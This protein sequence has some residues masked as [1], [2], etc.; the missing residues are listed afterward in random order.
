MGW[1]RLKLR[2][3]LLLFAV[4]IAAAPL[5]VAGQS[6]IRVAQDELKSSANEQLAVT[7]RQVSDEFN[8]FF[9]YS[10][11]PA[12]DLIRNAVGGVK[13]GS[14]AKIAL[15]RQGIA[16][17]PDVVS[18]QINVDGAP[19]P[20]LVV[21]EEYLGE[22][23]NKSDNPMAVLRLDR[24]PSPGDE[25][26]LPRASSVVFLPETGDW[27]ATASLPIPD[28]IGGRPANL[29]ARIRLDRLNSYVQD[30]PFAHTGTIQVMDA[31]ENLIFST[32]AGKYDHQVV[33][34]TAL[35][36]L[37]NNNATIAV[38]PF[39]LANGS[40]SLGAIALSRAFPWAILV[41]KDEADAYQTVADM[42]SSLIRWISVGIIAAGIGSLVFALGIS[43]PI[44]RIGQSAI[45]VAKGNLNTRVEGVTSKDE[46]GEL[47]RQF[48]DMIV[49]LN[50][51]FELQKFVSAGTMAAI[52]DSDERTV[53]LGG[54]RRRT[55]MLFA[56][57]R[58]YTAFS[59]NQDPEYVVD[60]LNQYFQRLS[61]VVVAHGGDIDK[62]V[63]D[64]IMAV[65]SGP[66]MEQNA[67]Q[68]AIDIMTAIDDLAQGNK[69]ELRIG[70][71]VDVGEVVVG[72][73]GSD[74]RKDFTVLG[75][76]VNTA[77][78][79]CSAA[80]PDET[81]I[82]E[83]TFDRLEASGQKRFTEQAPLEVKGKA[84]PLRVFS[85]STSET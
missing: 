46:I 2:T 69:A 40:I 55:A 25:A 32:T 29:H 41:E 68:C 57:I 31:E 16:D 13:L 65:F 45:E 21:Q 74:H 36:M 78:R 18:L 47:A 34:T 5:L 70:V 80:R 39:E 28:G 20:V 42:I 75:D 82:T 3:K 11:V 37:A 27:L 58:G 15:L 22:L 83:A 17:L 14:D 85:T 44:L 63:G 71:G 72:A 49:Q 64:Q 4:L 77:A 61:D 10:L 52:Q 76:H 24:P 38:E 33:T 23:Q 6:I 67:V 73:M 66:K 1:L 54:E 60:V 50:E 8:A 79:L 62:F 81:L 59:E 19:R 30:H 56:D 48:N 51:R 7:A 9:E 26:D 53:N 43:R 35:Q 12:L 84:K